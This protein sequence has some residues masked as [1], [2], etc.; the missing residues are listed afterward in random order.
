MRCLPHSV[1][2][3]TRCCGVAAFVRAAATHDCFVTAANSFG[4]MT[5]GIDAVLVHVHGQALMDR[6]QERIGLDFLGEQPVAS[7]FIIETGTPG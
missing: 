5:A 1:L 6:V 4:M 3:V 2:G 7:C